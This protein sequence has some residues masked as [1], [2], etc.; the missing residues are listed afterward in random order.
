M[1]KRGFPLWLDAIPEQLH[2]Q[3]IKAFENRDPSKFVW[4]ADSA[5]R[6]QLVYYNQFVLIEAGIFEKALLVAFI[7]GSANNSGFPSD[8]LRHLFEMA[9]SKRM[10]EAGDPLPGPGPFR[11]YRGVAGYG[12]A[13]KIRGFSWT[14]DPE[15]A[16]WFA[17]RFFDNILDRVTGSDPSV[18]DYILEEPANCPNCRWPV[19]EK[20]F[21][22]PK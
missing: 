10:R 11:L 1:I 20:T 22:E 13:R 5:A 8:D 4:C 3:A 14:S 6:L 17:N 12:R 19:R 15:R 21:V 16:R 18:T 2:T 9:D 7:S